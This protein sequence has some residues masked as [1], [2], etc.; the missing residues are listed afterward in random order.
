MKPGIR[1]WLAVTLLVG[2]M[3]AQSADVIVGA[4]E[5]QKPADTPDG[6]WDDYNAVCNA[7]TGVCSG[8]VG[9]V[10]LS[11]WTWA[12][13]G[14]V[15]AL[16]ERLI[17]P[18]TTEF[19]TATSVYSEFDSADIAAAVST[20]GPPTYHAF[21][22]VFVRGWTRTLAPSGNGQPVAYTP[23]LRD[24]VGTL[25]SHQCGSGNAVC[26]D[27][28]A[29]SGLAAQYPTNGSSF[30]GAWLYR[31]VP[32]EVALPLLYSAVIGVG[33]GRSLADQVAIVQAYLAVPDIQSA[34]VTLDAFR[35][36]VRAQS[37]KQIATAVAER[38]IADAA[39]ISAAIPCP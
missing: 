10:D 22:Y 13:N 34:C 29:L 36:H 5:W 31:L 23:Y 24:Y 11:G 18:A 4:R 2:P 32:P 28:A 39:D 3:A 6:S 12:S 19:P 21:D 7:T 33:P 15:Q 26:P 27:E 16:F 20:F 30:R 38:L 9:I 1:R 8:S 37:G 25:P 35:N 17:H 14:D